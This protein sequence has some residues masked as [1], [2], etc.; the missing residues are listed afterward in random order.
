M[1]NN[2]VKLKR[3]NAINSINNNPSN[4]TINRSIISINSTTGGKI[5]VNDTFDITCRITKANNSNLIGNEN[6]GLQSTYSGF[7]LLADYEAAF[8]SDMNKYKYSF[9]Y[10]GQ[11]FN[12]TSV[13]INVEQESI[14]SIQ[15]LCEVV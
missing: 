8:S 6:I 5:I 13:M 2:L 15:C 12:I 1:L 4:I 14:T 7:I 3:N 9:E 10:M 11:K